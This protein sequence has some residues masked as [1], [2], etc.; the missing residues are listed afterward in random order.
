MESVFESLEN[1]N[2]SEECFDEIMGIV[3]E[4]I[5]ET[6]Y[7][8]IDKKYGTGENKALRKKAI[9]NAKKEFSAA[10]DRDTQGKKGEKGVNKAL[11]VNRAHKR[12]GNG[13]SVHLEQERQLE[14]TPSK[15]VTNEIGKTIVKGNNEFDKAYKEALS[16]ARLARKADKKAE[17]AFDDRG[18]MTDKFNDSKDADQAWDT[19]QALNDKKRAAMG[20]LSDVNKKQIENAKYAKQVKHIGWVP[21]KTG[22]GKHGD[23]KVSESL[24]EEIMGLVEEFINELD[25]E[26]IKSFIKKRGEQ[27]TEAEKKFN[28]AK[29]EGTATHALLNDWLKKVSKY[30]RAR[31]KGMQAINYS[32]KR[33]HEAKKNVE[34]QKEKYG[35][36]YM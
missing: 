2:V 18:Y 35:N 25:K 14:K 9:A 31:E 19:A 20:K 15:P 29:A 7:D 17:G 8:A 16:A 13:P 26:T 34:E 1:L 11:E 30:Q 5:N 22:S 32:A 24:Y 10:F 6:I 36:K 33:R 23:V 3:K 12:L 28:K 27:K 4:V 21:N